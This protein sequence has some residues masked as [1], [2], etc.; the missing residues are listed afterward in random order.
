MQRE[1]ERCVWGG[2]GGR[3]AGQVSYMEKLDYNGTFSICADAHSV[4]SYP[5]N[6]QM[7]TSLGWS[8][9]CAEKQR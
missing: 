3:G 5:F 6:F 7:R 8:G 2:G 4:I 1:D 9:A